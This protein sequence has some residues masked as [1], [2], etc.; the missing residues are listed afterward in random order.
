MYGLRTSHHGAEEA[1]GKEL[2]RTQKGP[3]KGRKISLKRGKRAL[4]D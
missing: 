4:K 2:P 3:G 1:G